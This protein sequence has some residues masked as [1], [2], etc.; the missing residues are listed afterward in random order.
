[1][2][3]VR[4]LI[5]LL[6]CLTWGIAV[7]KLGDKPDPY[8]KIESNKKAQE[9]FKDVQAQ[10]RKNFGFSLA[11]PVRLELV[12]ESVMDQMMKASPYKG[13]EVGLYTMKN[14]QHHIYVMQ[15]WNRDYCAGVTA[16]EYT[17]A[18]QTE[19]VPAGQDIILRE[20]F[21]S[22]IEMK[23]FDSI[24]AY[25]Y[26]DNLRRQADPVYG[27]GIK[28]MMALEDKIG[29]RKLVELVQRASTMADVEK[30]LKK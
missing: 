21:A 15:G 27:V 11:L 13:A 6:C 26:A 7:A 12:H 29:P 3:T 5:L 17:H 2:R 16:H 22:W 18:W 23:Y 10:L 1:M 25:Q 4:P 20:G 28:T 14:G 30:V 8:E 24:G 9:V 19:R